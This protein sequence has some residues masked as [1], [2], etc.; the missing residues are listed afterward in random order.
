MT[1]T[2]SQSAVEKD[3]FEH[4][5]YNINGVQTAVLSIGS[6]PVLVFLHGTGTFT[7]FEAARQWSKAHTVLVPH[8]PGFGK[9]GDDE[10]LDTIEDYVLHY[11]D[12]FDHLGLDSFDL[13]GFS[14][15]AWIAAEY[16]I[17]QPERLKRLVLVAPA[18]LVDE[19]APAPNLLQI[20]PTE[21][22]SY[23]AH[24]PASVLKYF[25]VQPDPEFQAQ[26][27]R[28]IS[29]L[30]RLL[31]DNPQGNPK[32]ARWAHRIS[33]TTLV[34]WGA[35][36]RLRPTVQSR[37]WMELLPDARLELVPSTGHLVFEETPDASR[38][39]TD[40]LAGSSGGT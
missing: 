18:G 17:R 15:G 10:T 8:H 2:S 9:S 21:L 19:K 4:A 30:A 28:E 26:L 39:V 36:D 32:L 33:M 12:L 23:L 37:T 16:A 1:A 34:L 20:A 7:G 3:G 29:S 25:P 24:D 31:R 11:A 22:P 6:G 5:S 27:G 13:V 14:L 38:I 40:F 35:E